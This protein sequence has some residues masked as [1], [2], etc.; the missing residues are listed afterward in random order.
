MAENNEKAIT[1][2]AAIPFGEVQKNWGW[3]LALGI[4]FVILGIFG[5]GR[6]VALTMVSIIF[7]GILLLVGGVTQLIDSFKCKGWKGVIFHL[8]IAIVYLVAGIS[9]IANPLVASAFLTL[10]LG[11]AIIATGIMRI[12]MAIQHSGSPNWGWL[13]VGGILAVFMGAI[14]AA[15]WPIA[16]LWVIGLFVAIE[17]LINGWSYIFVAL[18]ARAASKAA[19]V[20]T[21]E[22]E[23]AKA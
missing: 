17:L 19:L 13:L 15:R 22:A 12:V 6:L 8:L 23:E 7:F 21:G 4:I 2:Q 3:V 5:L 11:F 1:S 20:G 16:G 9:V 10:V 14:I 18:A